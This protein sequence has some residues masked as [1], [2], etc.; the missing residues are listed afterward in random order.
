MKNLFKVALVAVCMSFVGNFAK[1]QSKIGYVNF[2]ALLGQ[3]PEAKTIKSQLD[4][5]QKQFVDQLTLMNNEL[6]TKGKEFSSQ[7]ATMTDATRTAKQTELQDLQK[8]MQDYENNAQQQVEA[9]TNELEKPLIDKGRAAV[10]EVAKEKGYSYVFNTAQTELL[11][12]PEA[13]DLGA[14]VKLKLGF[15]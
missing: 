15:K 8:R 7:S 2:Q 9:K 10:S 11:V 4:I 12:S 6:Q 3:M 14:A 1:A 5:Y 13:D